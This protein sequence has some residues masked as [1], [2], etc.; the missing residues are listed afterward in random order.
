MVDTD[1]ALVARYLRGD[2]DA[3]RALVER[4]AP[5]VYNLAYRLTGD[6]VEAA[7]ITQETLRRVFEALPT[8]RSELPF[9]PWV[10]H[11]AL[12]LCR[13]WARR[14]RS[15]PA[16]SLNE[17]RNGRE[18]GEELGE[19]VADMAPL[20]PDL[21]EAEETRHALERA[22]DELPPAYRAAIILRYAE[23]LSYQEI[24]AALGLPLNTVRTHLAR[25]KRLLQAR[26]RAEW[27]TEL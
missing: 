4:R 11:I 25:G 23:D 14:Q 17:T 18:A 9:K 27:G 12:N 20:P 5:E 26:L 19:S 3:F 8:S 15:T 22:I 16:A 10:L 21:L 2:R 1:E 7:D 6:A 24:A 13:D